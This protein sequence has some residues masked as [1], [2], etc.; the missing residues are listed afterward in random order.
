MIDPHPTPAPPASTRDTSGRF[1]PG[2]SGNPKG[3]KPGTLN[4]ATILKQ[5]LEDGDFDVA[6]QTFRTALHAGNF[7]AARLL[8]D[9]L[10]PKPRNRP[11]ALEVP[12]DLPMPAR[13]TFVSRAMFRGE[14]TPDEAK[15][16]VAVL[17]AEDAAHRRQANQEARDAMHKLTMEI[18][19]PEL[20]RR[21]EETWRQCYAPRGDAATERDP[22]SEP[23]LHSTCNS[24]AGEESEAPVTPPFVRSPARGRSP[25]G[26]PSAGRDVLH[27]ACMSDPGYDPASVLPTKRRRAVNRLRADATRRAAA[28]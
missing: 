5:A 14:I 27:S 16:M 25:G 6:V 24:P 8:I 26:E 13:F 20:E 9:R 21:L 18:Y 28:G 11:I 7:V 22:E 19:R 12:D 3:K 1:Q 4:K 2:R 15:V 10:D 23:D 17:E